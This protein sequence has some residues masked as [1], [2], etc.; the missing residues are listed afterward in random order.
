MTKNAHRPRDGTSLI[1]ALASITLLTVG[2]LGIAATGVASLRLETSAAQRA[3]A[4]RIA[5]SR[6]EFLH[7]ACASASGTDTGRGISAAWHTTARGGIQ[8][9]VDSVVFLDR[10]AGVPRTD[11]IESAAPC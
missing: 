11:V 5:G 1:E 3:T 7:R 4:A 9:I 10:L 2:A 6:L 8:E